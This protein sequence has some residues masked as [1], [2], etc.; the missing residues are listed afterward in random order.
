MH[1]CLAN[2]VASSQ[3]LEKGVT[4]DSC[5]SD[6]VCRAQN[7]GQV[8]GDAKFKKLKV[9]YP[10]ELLPLPL[11]VPPAGRICDPARRAAIQLRC[12]RE[13]VKSIALENVTFKQ[14]F[15]QIFKQIFYWK[16]LLLNH[17]SQPSEA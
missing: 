8:G 11:P 6:E 10:P 4:N 15:R 13:V 3:L 5:S 17:R 1:T 16:Y 7:S 2:A 12:Y 14:I 9:K